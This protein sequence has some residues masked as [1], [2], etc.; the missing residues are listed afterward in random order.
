MNHDSKLNLAM[1][2]ETSATSPEKSMFSLE[3]KYT[4]AWK[5]VELIGH[6]ATHNHE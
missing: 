6:M 1:V 5:K 4:D 3:P 2:A